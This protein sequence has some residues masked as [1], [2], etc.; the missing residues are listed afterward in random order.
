MSVVALA[1]RIQLRY[2][3]L[4][5]G[6]NIGVLWMIG[7]GPVWQHAI[8]LTIVAVLAWIMRF[9]IIA[10]ILLIGHFLVLLQVV[11]LYE[12]RA[13]RDYAQ[14]L[15]LGPLLMVAGA[16]STYSLIFGLILIGY[17]LLALYCCLLF[18]LKVE[19]DHARRVV[20]RSACGHAC[21]LRE[22][23]AFTPR[24]GWRGV[25]AT[26]S[27]ELEQRVLAFGCLRSARSTCAASVLLPRRIA[28]PRCCTRAKP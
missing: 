19:T 26:R 10:P 14:L 6:V 8:T 28:L 11:K 16:I 9:G 17:L 2:R 22:G 3:Y 25:H 12:Q 1:A 7:D 23:E 18:H 21:S 27:C 13:N 24:A 4:L 5:A 15:V 20:P